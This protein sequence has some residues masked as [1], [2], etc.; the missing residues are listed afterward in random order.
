[1]Q[2]FMIT[3]FP[4]HEILTLLS[5]RVNRNMENGA[6]L[7]KIIINNVTMFICSVVIQCSEFERVPHVKVRVFVI[8][9]NIYGSKLKTS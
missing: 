1:M 3:P 8:N 4:K 2:P 7:R 6:A 5:A 9:M